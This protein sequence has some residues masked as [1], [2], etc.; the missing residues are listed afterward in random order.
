MSIKRKLI[1]PD[2]REAIYRSSNRLEATKKYIEMLNNCNS[3]EAKLLR[4]KLETDYLRYISSVSSQ[5]QTEKLVEKIHKNSVKI[6]PAF[7][8]ITKAR[9]KSLISHYNKDLSA[10]KDGKRLD[11]IMDTRACRIFL[12]FK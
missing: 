7:S 5:S 3:L 8:V 1:L 11:Q 12:D 2:I 9:E 6:F 10:L 4:N